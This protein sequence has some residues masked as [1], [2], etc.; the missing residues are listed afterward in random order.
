[1]S[2]NL[3]PES[4]KIIPFPTKTRNFAA[5]PPTPAKILSTPKPPIQ[6]GGSWYHQTAIDDAARDRKP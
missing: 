5:N 1:M 6:W 3:G 2:R 4:A